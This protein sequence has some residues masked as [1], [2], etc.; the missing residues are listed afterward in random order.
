[1]QGHEFR[2]KLPEGVELSGVGG[3]HPRDVS[4]FARVR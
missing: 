2:K 1:M 4:A 3:T